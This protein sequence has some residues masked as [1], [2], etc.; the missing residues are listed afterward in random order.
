VSTIP[1]LRE[2][3]ADFFWD[4]SLVGGL[5]RGCCLTNIPCCNIRRPS[6]Y[7]TRVLPKAASRFSY[8][9]SQGFSPKPTL[10]LGLLRIHAFACAT[11]SSMTNLCLATATARTECQPHSDNRLPNLRKR[12]Q[13][14]DNLSNQLAML[15]LQD[16]ESS[17]VCQNLFHVT[18]EVS[19]TS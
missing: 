15:S 7:D 5:A 11:L 2:L 16:A 8:S 10:I 13:S 4:N 12:I 9:T 1:C 17:D 6:L 14:N 18:L 19:C 3:K